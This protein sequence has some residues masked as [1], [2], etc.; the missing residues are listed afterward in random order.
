MDDGRLSLALDPDQAIPVNVTV[1][2]TYE[3]ALAMAQGALAP[4][5]ALAAGRVRVRGELAVLVAGQA[6]LAA[7]TAALGPRLAE[8][9]DLN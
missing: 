3:D 1:V 2:L 6:V 4:A 9:T 5:D 7:A 8:L